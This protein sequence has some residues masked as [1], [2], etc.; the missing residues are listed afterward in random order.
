MT[1][2]VYEQNPTQRKQTQ[3]WIIDQQQQQT[4]KEDQTET[5]SNKLIGCYF[6]SAV[7]GSKWARLGVKNK[8]IHTQARET[9]HTDSKTA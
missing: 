4:N 8:K 3:L 9:K 6:T 7:M 1:R 5:K 2:Q